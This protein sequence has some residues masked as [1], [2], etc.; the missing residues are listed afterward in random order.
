MILREARDTP[1]YQC[2]TVEFHDN[3][4]MKKISKGLDW[5]VVFT[6][7]IAALVIGCVAVYYVGPENV[8]NVIKCVMQHNGN[9]AA[10]AAAT[11]TSV[12]PTSSNTN[13][14]E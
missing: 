5:K 12:L 13:H 9:I 11:T 4:V 7:G 14:V 6:F 2:I 1:F 8:V 10:V 3:G